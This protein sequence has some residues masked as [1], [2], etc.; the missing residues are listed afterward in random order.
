M[1]WGIRP[2]GLADVLARLRRDYPG[3]PPQYVTENG[4]A[5]GDEVRDGRVADADRTAGI[6][7]FAR[8]ER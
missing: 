2:D 3:L 8:E 4:A 1:G 5:F 6:V 7:T